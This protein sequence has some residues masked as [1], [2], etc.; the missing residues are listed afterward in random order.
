MDYE[1]EVILPKDRIGVLIGKEGEVKKRIEEET[2]TKIIV[3]AKKGV[4]RV[5]RTDETD[6]FLGIKAIE[7]VRAIALGFPPEK[8]FKLLSPSMYL[9]VVDL[10]EISS[11]LRRVKSRVIGTQGKARKTIERHTRTDVVIQDKYVGILGDI[12]GV[13]IAKE[14][15]LRLAEGSPHSAV[16]RFLERNK[17]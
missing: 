8:A 13:R 12:E 5:I 15:V 16:Y 6:P 7:I 3:D 14:A 4:A 1:N 9:E 11:D 17:R 2:G 10:E